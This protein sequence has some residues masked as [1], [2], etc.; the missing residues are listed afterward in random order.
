MSTLRQI[1]GRIRL[2]LRGKN[3]IVGWSMTPN[4]AISFIKSQGKTVLTFFGYSAIYE[5][6]QGML[7]IARSVL[8]KYS[9]AATLVNIGA[10]IGGVGAI[11]PLAKSM[12]FTTTGVVSTLALEHPGEI[13]ASV[14]HLCFIEDKQWGGKIADS[15]DLSPISK[16]MVTCSDILVAIGGN[17]IARDELLA[18]RKQGKPI[19]YHPA[20]INHEW[21]ISRAKRMGLPPPESFWGSV[22]EVFGK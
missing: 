12:G 10:T 19:H 13:S 16:A 15:N 18:G 14:D 1:V 8:T 2:Q 11:Y 3:H 9:P 17:D 6:R 20:E 22:H 7:R 4:E 21:L 5:D